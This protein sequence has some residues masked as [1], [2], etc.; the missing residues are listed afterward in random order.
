MVLVGIYRLKRSPASICSDSSVVR[1]ALAW[2][3]VRFVNLVSTE[4]ER[5]PWPGHSSTNPRACP[6]LT[7]WPFSTAQLNPAFASGPSLPAGASNTSTI[8]LPN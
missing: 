2:P 6:I 5:G 3:C 1:S 4:R 7:V 8:V